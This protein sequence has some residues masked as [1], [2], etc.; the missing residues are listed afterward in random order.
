MNAK[1]VYFWAKT[2]KTYVVFW[3]YAALAIL[4]IPYFISKPDNLKG[5]P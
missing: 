2:T 1:D 4:L 3:G 5:D